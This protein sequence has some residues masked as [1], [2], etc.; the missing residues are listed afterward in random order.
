MP[1]MRQLK[2][3]KAM[4]RPAIPADILPSVAEPAI[5]VSIAV[6]VW[7]VVN[8]IQNSGTRSNILVPILVGA[9]VPT[10]GAGLQKD[11]SLGLFVWQAHQM[12][13]FG[14]LFINFNPLIFMSG[15]FV[16]IGRS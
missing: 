10:V 13:I 16:R 4:R 11:K 6:I 12:L 8:G 15:F 5:N 2:A 9:A 3:C 14:R 7:A 1:S